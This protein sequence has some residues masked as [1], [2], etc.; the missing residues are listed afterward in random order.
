MSECNACHSEIDPRATKCPRCQAFQSW[1]RNPQFYSWLAVAPLVALM[2][3]QV[4][5]FKS[6]DFAAYQGQFSV[7]KVADQAGESGS[8][9]MTYRIKNGTG[10]KW[11]RLRY[12]LVGEDDKGKTVISEWGSEWSWMVQPREEAFVTVEAKNGAGVSTW[13]FRIADLDSRSF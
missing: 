10:L 11:E 7:E 1:Y 3:W 8:R 9:M 2:L 4:R 13:K 12:E 6:A 5:T